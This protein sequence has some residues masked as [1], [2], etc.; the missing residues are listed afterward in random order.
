MPQYDCQAFW[1]APNDCNVKLVSGFASTA[2]RKLSST[3]Y[4]EI[5]AGD[6][7]RGQGGFRLDVKCD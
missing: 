4:T 3:E 6:V 1:I 2:E 5:K 7:I